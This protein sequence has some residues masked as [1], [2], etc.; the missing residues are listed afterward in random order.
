MYSMKLQQPPQVQMEYEGSHRAHEG[1][2]RVRLRKQLHII[3]ERS[4]FFVMNKATR[5]NTSK[6]RKARLSFFAGSLSCT[7]QDRRLFTSTTVAPMTR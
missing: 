4:S 5:A 6:C 3:S 1:L 2:Q 7:R